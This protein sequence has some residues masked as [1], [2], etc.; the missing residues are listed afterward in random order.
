MSAGRTSLDTNRCR[1]QRLLG[2]RWTCV[3]SVGFLLCSSV[4]RWSLVPGVMESRS[5]IKGILAFLV[6]RTSSTRIHHK[7]YQVKGFA[8]SHSK[9]TNMRWSTSFC[10]DLDPTRSKFGASA[11]LGPSGSLPA[12]LP[13]P[14]WFPWDGRG[15]QMIARHVLALHCQKVLKAWS[16]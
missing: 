1:P 12:S 6:P 16:L 10:W 5:R 8:L 4:I 3:A 7:W 9:R 11:A 13:L 2:N 15:L 14:G